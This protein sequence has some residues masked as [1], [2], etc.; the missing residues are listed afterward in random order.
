MSRTPV[1][2]HVLN[3]YT[4]NEQSPDS[5]CPL[6]IYLRQVGDA[7]LRCLRSSDN[8]QRMVCHLNWGKWTFVAGN[9]RGP[10]LSARRNTAWLR[11]GP[12]A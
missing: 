7:D 9:E 4:D 11:L 8:R 2:Q 1:V 5:S 10:G 3:L 6:S 12:E